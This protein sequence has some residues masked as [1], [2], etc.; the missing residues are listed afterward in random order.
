MVLIFNTNALSAPAEGE[1]AVAKLV[2]RQASQ[3]R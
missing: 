2:A 1:E 3:F